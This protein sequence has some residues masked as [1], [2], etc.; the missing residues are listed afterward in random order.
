MDWNERGAVE[1]CRGLGMM[2]P[3]TLESV[4]GLLN[5]LCG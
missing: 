5:E 3:E 1:Y 2:W 4:G